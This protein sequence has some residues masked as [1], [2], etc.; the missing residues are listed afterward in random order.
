[1]SGFL[2]HSLVGH[3]L[4]LL[5]FSWV[6][7]PANMWIFFHMLDCLALTVGPSCEWYMGIPISHA[8]DC[9]VLRALIT[10]HCFVNG[11]YPCM[12]LLGLN[13]CVFFLSTKEVCTSK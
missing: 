1:L 6:D 2:F 13:D 3:A 10:G 12:D 9:I 11:I 5:A 8:L 7:R 4:D